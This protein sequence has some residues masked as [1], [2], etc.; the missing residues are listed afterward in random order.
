M[1]Q[2]RMM[3]TYFT[4]V[5][6][7]PCILAMNFQGYCKRTGTKDKVTNKPFKG[8]ELVCAEEM[9]WCGSCKPCADGYRTTVKGS[10]K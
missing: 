10:T 9:L 1:A 7:I 6:P 2:A 5:L 8:G 3:G 4:P